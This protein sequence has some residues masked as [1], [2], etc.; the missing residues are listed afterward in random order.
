M[1]APYAR[2]GHGATALLGPLVGSEEA[3]SVTRGRTGSSERMTPR[4]EAAAQECSADADSLDT[5]YSFYEADERKWPRV[6]RHGPW[7]HF[8]SATDSLQPKTRILPSAAA[9]IMPT[10]VLFVL[11]SVEGSW[12]K[13]APTLDGLR[14]EKG[15]GYIVGNAVAVGLAFLSGLTIGLRSLDILRRYFSLTV[16]M[17]VQVFVNLLV[18]AVCI[19]V[20]AI[21]QRNNINDQFVWITP[22]YPCIYAGAFL[23]FLQ[24]AMLIADYAT[25]RNFNQRGHGL[26]GPAMQ[27]AILLA[28]VVAIWTGFGSM[29]F[30]AVEDGSFWHPYISCYNAW[31]LL[32]TTGATNLDIRTT[33]S[34]VFIFFWLPIG[35]LLMFV[36]FCCFGVGFVQRF[37]EKPL[38]RIS[39]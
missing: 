21:Y 4:R 33:N 34:L 31:V 18:G 20:G 1:D 3:H 11:T 30:K 38:R 12:I 9:V 8:Y 36:F 26:G 5:P 23:A 16:A 39:E 27:S 7:W 19:M 17:L 15:S 28:N 2:V 22:E 25:T 35:L 24:A 6:L 14:I 37:D 10:A 29:V 32:I 13:K